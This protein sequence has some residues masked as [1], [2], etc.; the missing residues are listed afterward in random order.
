MSIKATD[1]ARPATRV[2]CEVAITRP[3]M[4]DALQLSACFFA[5]RTDFARQGTACGIAISTYR[6]CRGDRCLQDATTFEMVAQHCSLISWLISKRHRWIFAV[7]F[8]FTLAYTVRA[9]YPNIVATNWPFFPPCVYDAW[10][11]HSD[12]SGRY[13]I[14]YISWKWV[15]M[16]REEIIALWWAWL[17][18]TDDH[19][20][21]SKQTTD[22]RRTASK[23]WNIR[24]QKCI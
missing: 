16:L 12:S 6:V 2:S 3:G 8:S 21:S 10:F 13:F 7:G 15:H 24:T 19:I 22:M 5:P 18:T 1:L 17:N 4:F 23:I 14:A 9:L 11:D 20:L